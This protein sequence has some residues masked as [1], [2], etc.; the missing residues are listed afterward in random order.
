M[1]SVPRATVPGA[2]TVAD[3]PAP[4]V[5]VGISA[6]AEESPDRLAVVLEPVRDGVLPQQRRTFRELDERSRRLGGYL[7]DVGLRRGDTVAVLMENRAEFFEAC[8]AAHRAGLFYVPIAT[9]LTAGE[10][11]F[12]VEDSG[13]KVLVASHRLL[14]LAGEIASPGSNH[15]LVD[16]STSQFRNYEEVLASA[17]LLEEQSDGA[18]LMYSSGTSGRPKGVETALPEAPWGTP[19]NLTLRMR[20]WYGI[21]PGDVYLSPGPLY[22]SAPLL[23]SLAAQRLGATVVQLDRFDA[24][25]ALAAIE[26]WG[27]THSQWVPSMFHRLLELPAEVRDRY[28]LSTHRAAIHAAAPCP[29]EL[30]QRMFDWWGPII[31]EYYSASERVGATII[32]PQEWLAKPGSVGKP[33]VGT[34]H[35]CDDDGNELPPG[36][37]GTIWFEGG[38]T[39][40]Y[41]NDPDKTRGAR[42]ARGWQTVFDMGSLDEDGYLYLADRRSDLIITGGVNV[43]PREIELALLDHP[44][45]GDAAV[46]GVPDDRF[47]Q[48]IVAMIEPQRGHRADVEALHDHLRDRLAPFKRP[49]HILVL[50]ELP[51]T[52]SGKLRRH[53][54]ARLAKSLITDLL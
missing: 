6:Y 44:S 25:G 22:H 54:T 19:D 36:E 49:R 41:R 18:A 50:D 30:K 32:S 29:V 39:F 45:I 12:I 24:E 9:S 28:D 37:V 48:A 21:G 52:E 15:L 10:A 11:R 14:D 2:E 43:Y 51:R 33:M 46:V 16:G 17:P 27:V 53:E 13:A 31:W 47:G 7:C 5:S 34:P 38:P 35:I 4:D 1:S 8:W 3:S 42:D 20:Q 23:Y 26:R 40:E